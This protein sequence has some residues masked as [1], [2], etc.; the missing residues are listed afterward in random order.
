MKISYKFMEQMR[1]DIGECQEK[2]QSVQNL[3]YQRILN[4]H[5]IHAILSVRLYKS[6]KNK[7]LN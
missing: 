3:H 4:M 5:G 2:L 6:N 7:C 1:R